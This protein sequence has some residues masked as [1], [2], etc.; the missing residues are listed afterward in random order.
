ML[1]PQI[2]SKGAL[3]GNA[4]ERIGIFTPEDCGKSDG[5]ENLPRAGI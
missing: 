5:E 3:T 4:A 2:S 1:R